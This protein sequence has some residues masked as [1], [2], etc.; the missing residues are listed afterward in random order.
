MSREDDLSI[1]ELHRKRA[2]A[3]AE[4][5]AA[6]SSSSHAGHHHAPIQTTP[7][8]QMQPRVSVS[9]PAIERAGDEEEG[10][11]W[12]VDTG[13]LL[14]ALKRHW[15]WLIIGAVIMG[16]AGAGAGYYKGKYA[17]SMMLWRLEIGSASPIFTPEKISPASLK[18]LLQS[19]ELM[20]RVAAKANPPIAV[21][22]LMSSVSVWDDKQTELITISMQSQNAPALPDLLNLYANEAVAFTREHQ[23]TPV[24]SDIKF[25]GEQIA[26]RDSEIKK[27]GAELIEFMRTNNIT[28]P[29]SETDAYAK[30]LGEMAGQIKIKTIDAELVEP[31]IADLEAELR[32]Q[33][34]LSDQLE[35]AKLRM[36]SLLLTKTELHPDVQGVKA[37]IAMLTSKIAEMGT[38]FDSSMKFPPGSYAASLQKQIG[39]LKERKRT[40]DTQIAGL[41]EAREELLKAGGGRLVKGS[42][43]ATIKSELDTL[44]EDRKR[45]WDIQRAEQQYADGAKG[46]VRI[47]SPATQDDVEMRPRFKKAVSFGFKGA[48]GGLAFAAAL[49]LLVELKDRTMK[50][51]S[52]VEKVTGLR[53]LAAL[54]DLNEMTAEERDKWAFRAWTVMAGQL[55]ASPNH[56][57]VCGFVSSGRG[58][59]RS[60]WIKL[61][62]NAASQ[63]G[64]RVLTVATKPSGSDEPS[65]EAENATNEKSFSE[66]VDNAMTEVESKAKAEAEAQ[67]E[68]GVVAV[69]GEVHTEM[70]SP[71]SL[72]FPAEVTKKFIAGEMPAAHIPLP[73]WVWNLDRRRQWQMAL[74]HWRGIDNL[75]LL[76]ELPPASVPE[77]VLLAESLPQLIW[78]VDS[79]KASISATKEQLEMM[80]HAQC[81]IV[82]AVL[83]HEPKP[84]I[85]L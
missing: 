51:V 15:Y 11:E 42:E 34:P 85:K 27:M 66:A 9:A 8:V 63:R 72:A 37:E 2:A 76:V 22:R 1:S 75:V 83:N 61:L 67:A 35:S 71:N 12:S 45:I 28:D 64:L 30:D 31:Q 54:G 26:A 59:G 20:R 3:Q 6:Q 16:G 25:L 40:L 21:D 17:A 10:S 13:R 80:R 48:L 29:K 70:L 81:Q 52:E 84:I 24:H 49:V 65:T 14:A 4:T 55:N 19:S 32:K 7:V 23:L 68:A 58:E 57:M 73:G 47:N 33:N 41:K 50:T 69:E 43:Y 5:A 38:N 44:T 53:V 82:G 79:G 60:T 39:E 74:A 78:L 62:G 56:G 77:S 46:Y 36:A 18:S